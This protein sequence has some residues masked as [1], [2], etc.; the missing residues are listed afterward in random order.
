[1]QNFNY[2]N[3]VNIIF[4]RGTI[5]EL[6]NLISKDSKILMTYGGGS[7]KKNGIYAQVKKALKGYSILEFS[8]IEPNPTYETCI[9]AVKIVKENDIDFLLAVGGGSVLDAT[10]FISAASKFNDG[11]PWK[12]LSEAAEV[13]SALPLA[14][15]ITL[16]ATGSEMNCGAVMSKKSTNEKYPLADKYLFPQFSIIDPETTYS[17]P[18]KQVINGLVDTYV[19]VLEQYVTYNENA[20]LQ[21]RQAE[22]ILLT[23][24]EIAEKVLTESENYDAKADFFWCSTQALNG[25]INCGLPQDW[26]THLIGHELTALYGIDHAQSIAIVLPRLWYNQKENKADK[27]IQYGK[28]VFNISDINRETAL[29]TI[30]N[31]TK[32]FFESLGIKTNLSDYGINSEDAAQKISQRFKERG[33]ILGERENITPDDVKEILL[34]C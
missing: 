1:M 7:I 29:N 13:K 9:K 24:H 18:Q 33:T 10:K 2:Y 5:S 6:P 12:L 28:R 15:V 25:I 22:S 4:G 34:N 31:K 20:P 8:G 32:D 26:T 21:N 30:I 3:P 11:D 27:L 23:I 19:H 14:S 16:P 17:L